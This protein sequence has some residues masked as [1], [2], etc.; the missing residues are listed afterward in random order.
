MFPQVPKREFFTLSIQNFNRYGNGIE[1]MHPH[2]YPL[3]T[4]IR[5]IVFDRMSGDFEPRQRSFS[6]CQKDY[7][8][9]CR[10]CQTSAKGLFLTDLVYT[11]SSGIAVLRAR[12]PDAYQF[13]RKSY[14]S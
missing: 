5:L 13:N 2:V 4:A 12:H 6:K 9:I 3:Q 7:F 8:T 14:Q 11:M 10:F 1:F